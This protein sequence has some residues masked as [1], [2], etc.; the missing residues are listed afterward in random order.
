MP[1]NMLLDIF[2][3]SIGRIPSV[4]N[5]ELKQQ[6]KDFAMTEGADLVGIAP[7]EAYS[8][9]LTEIEERIKETGASRADFMIA[10]DDTTFFERISCALNT[11]PTAKSII[12]IGVYSYD[13]TAAYQDVRG[14]L[15]GKTARTYSY[16]PVAR[17]VAGKLTAHIQDLGYNATHGQDVPLKYVADRI[18]LGCYGKHGIFITEEFG[19]YTGLRNV[20]T[21]APLEPDEFQ[22]VPLCQDCDRCLEACPTG[23]LYAPY[24]VNPRLCLNPITR[25]E[26][27]IAPDMRSKMQNWISGCD[28]CQEVCPVNQRLIP[29]KPDPRSGFYP[30]Y[31]SSHR[32]LSALEKM[33][34]LLDLLNPDH[35]DIIRRNAVIALANTGI[36]NEEALEAL[37]NRMGDASEEL[38]DYFSWA[39]EELSGLC[40]SK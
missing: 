25:R 36:G 3:T 15:R 28:I 13:E 37:K 22:R 40:N 39:I 34:G 24:K 26:K 4:R 30:E 32:N 20:L 12:M 17:Q 33:P 1:R 8:D 19:S 29:R 38:R 2:F 9:Y 31:H 10:A 21:D 35:P 6:I 23:A 27:H 14:E 7:V 16:Y 18:G 5:A 11:M